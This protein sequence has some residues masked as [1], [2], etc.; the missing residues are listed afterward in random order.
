MPDI[1]DGFTA[2][3]G[4]TGKF[5]ESQVYAD[6]RNSRDA[7]FARIMAELLCLAA[8]THATELREALANVLPDFAHMQEMATRTMALVAEGQAKMSELAQRARRAEEWM[9]AMEDRL[10]AAEYEREQGMR[11]TLAIGS[12]NGTTGHKAV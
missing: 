9:K 12:R 5:T 4:L 8:H 3:L 6:L 10:S 11:P 1:V 7:T 2:S